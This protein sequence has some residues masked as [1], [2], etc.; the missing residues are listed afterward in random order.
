M[1]SPLVYGEGS[2]QL[3]N[4]HFAT[5]STEIGSDK[6][7][8]RMLNLGGNV[9]KE[10]AMCMVLRAFKRLHISCQGKRIIALQWTTQTTS[11]PG[12]QN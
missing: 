10:Q 7:H 11:Y 5:I 8:Q 6:N 3:A 12:D 2:L 9:D 1:R 4:H